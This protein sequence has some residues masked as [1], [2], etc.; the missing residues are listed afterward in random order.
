[1]DIVRALMMGLGFFALLVVGSCAMIGYGTVA[2]VEKAAEIAKEENASKASRWN[3]D[4][5]VSAY[6]AAAEA[7]SFERASRYN[8]SNVGEPTMALD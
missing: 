6:A 8:D 5:A 7:E 3:D 4:A 1:M 2:V